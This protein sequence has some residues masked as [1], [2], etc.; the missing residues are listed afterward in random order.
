MKQRFKH[1]I[2]R[3]AGSGSHGMI[4]AAITSVLL[5]LT[6]LAGDK[7]DTTPDYTSMVNS[8]AQGGPDS[9]LA[10]KARFYLGKYTNYKEALVT[11][12]HKQHV[13]QPQW[14]VGTPCVSGPDHGAM[15]IHLV[16]PNRFTGQVFVSEPTA[17]IYEPQANGDLVLVGLEYIRDSKAWAASKEG[18]AGPPS[19][20]G[21]LFNFVDEPNRYGLHAFYELHLWAFAT[22]PKGTFAD[23]NTHVTCEKQP[24]GF[25]VKP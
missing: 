14:V 20:D 11:D 7:V 24:V 18:K 16:N 8:Q 12:N 6:A 21:Q 2:R 25:V 19:L 15:G 9:P 4:I 3:A 17:L 1:I 5:P 10:A 23:W 13:P 22:N